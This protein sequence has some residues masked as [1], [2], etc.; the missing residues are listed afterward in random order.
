MSLENMKGGFMEENKISNEDSILASIKK[1]LGTTEDYNHFDQDIIMYINGCFMDLHQLGVGP[2][3]GFAIFDSEA[4]WV[5][6]DDN[7]LLL[8]AIKPYIY[9]KVKLIF[10]PPSSAS[11]IKSFENIIDKFEWRINMIHEQ[12]I[13]DREEVVQHDY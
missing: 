7:V 12:S 4:A 6:F 10:D 11:V 1:L 2:D 9:L 13:A 3:E 8:N 5:D